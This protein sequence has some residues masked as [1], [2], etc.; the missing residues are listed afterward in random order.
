[1]RK[2]IDKISQFFVS[3]GI[4]TWIHMVVVLVVSAIIA[5]ICFWTGADRVLAACVGS[6]LGL[7][8]GFL[9]EVYDSKTTKVFSA[10]DMVGD[11]IGAVLFWLIF[12]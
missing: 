1:M 6:F 8:V 11:A 4:D 5:R 7:I 2:Y 10:M 3:L 9:K 12:I